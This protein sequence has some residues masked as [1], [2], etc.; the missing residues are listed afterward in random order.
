MSATSS[1][2][3]VGSFVGAAPAVEVRFNGAGGVVA[4]SGGGAGEFAPEIVVCGRLLSHHRRNYRCGHKGFYKT[5]PRFIASSMKTLRLSTMWQSHVRE[6]VPGIR[7]QANARRM[8]RYPGRYNISG[9]QHWAFRFENVNH[10]EDEESSPE[11]REYRGLRQTA[12]VDADR[13]PACACLLVAG[14]AFAQGFRGFETEMTASATAPSSEFHL[15]AWS[16]PHLPQFHL[17]DSGFPSAR[18]SRVRLVD[19][20]LARCR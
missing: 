10:C 9:I 7:L 13:P 2:T 4:S 8:A 18:R 12:S 17:G 14:V 19:D 3:P 1:A 20:G 5:V 11:A 15:S 6:A 16:I